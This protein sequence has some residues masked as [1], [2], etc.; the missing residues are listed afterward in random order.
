MVPFLLVFFIANS[1]WGEQTPQWKGKIETVDGLKVVRNPNAPL[2]GD[3]KLNL[4]EDLQIGKED[5]ENY[6]FERIRRVKA[7]DDGSIFVLDIK[8]AKIQK[9]DKNGTYLLTIG[10][11]GQGPG[12][13]QSP[14]NVFIHPKT[15][16]IYVQDSIRLKIFDPTGKYLRE[17]LLRNYP[18]EFLVDEE[19]NIWSVG[20]KQQEKGVFKALTEIGPQG[21]ILNTIAE[22]PYNLYQ[23]RTGENMVMTLS[24]GYEYDLYFTGLLPRAYVYG[25]SEKYELSVIDSTGKNVLKIFK[26]EVPKSFTPGDVKGPAAESLPKYKPFF[27]SL[28]SDDAGRIYVLKTIPLRELKAGDAVPYDVF[29]KDGVFLYKL[30]LPYSQAFDIRS[31]YLY[32][33]HAVEDTGLEVI[34]RFKIANWGQIRNSMN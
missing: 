2:F 31:G 17:I 1:S 23:K 25:Y 3:L 11:K 15:H 6:I 32:A 24:T 9:Y 27:Y 10:K 26:D 16:E 30:E 21:G 34:K 4:L 8:A 33:R 18:T 28:F 12:E 13:F 5:G 29:G 20:G 7:T 22:A 19:G 14:S